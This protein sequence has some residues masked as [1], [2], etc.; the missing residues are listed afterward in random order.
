[1]LYRR[2]GSANYWC[3]FRIGNRE[4]RQSCGTT[5]KTAAEE[6]EQRLRGRLWREI[7]LGERTAT[8]E[9]AT[10]R[11]LK[12][13]NLRPSTRTRTATILEW[14]AEPMERLPLSAIT[15]EVIAAAKDALLASRSA[16]TT[17]RYLAVLRAVLNHAR[18]M[19]WL[20][21]VPR[22]PLVT[23]ERKEPRWL[24]REQFATLVEH[25]P[26]H[27]KAPATFSVLTG[28]R[29]GNVQGLTWDRV[30]LD[31]AHVWI[32]A[33][34]AKGRRTISVPLPAEA[35]QLLEG[36]AREPGQPRVFLYRVRDKHGKVLAVR[37]MGSPKTAFGKAVKR[38]GVA[39]LRW[40]DL[41]HTWASWLI[42]DGV[43]AAVVQHL[44]GWASGQM[45]E[46]YGHLDPNYLKQW[47]ARTKT[48]S[49]A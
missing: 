2:K 48:G 28:L 22:V 44:G 35:V 25:L 49:A 3:R 39:P 34:T 17:N 8:W 16:S 13:A 40:H 9:Q 18:D 47:A 41:R 1:M 33:M 4:V 46:R 19:G 43:P 29:L 26:E 20:R 7:K 23:V 42:Q 5:D 11:W 37:P 15:P 31:K 32:P 27:L 38:A 30:S 24:T 12:D 6:Y 21:T 45:V 36:L 14:F 10:E